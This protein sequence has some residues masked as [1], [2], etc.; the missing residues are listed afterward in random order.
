MEGQSSVHRDVTVRRPK[1][2]HNRRA[3]LMKSV[4]ETTELQANGSIGGNR[5]RSLTKS[6]GADAEFKSKYKLNQQPGAVRSE[7]RTRLH[8]PPGRRRRDRQQSVGAAGRQ[9][10]SI[11]S[12]AAR[13]PS[14]SPER[15]QLSASLRSNH[16]TPRPA[17]LGITAK[18]SSMRIVIGLLGALLWPLVPLAGQDAPSDVQNDRVTLNSYYG[19]IPFY[20]AFHQRMTTRLSILKASRDSELLSEH[21]R[22]SETQRS[23]I[24]STWITDDGLLPEPVRNTLPNANLQVDEFQIDPKFY[25]F[26]EPEQRERLDRLAIEFDGYAGLVLNSV[27]ERVKLSPETVES[28]RTMLSEYHE[29]AW[30]PFFRYEFAGRLP[31]DHKYRRCV[32]VG[33]YAL[34]V[35]KAILSALNDDEQRRLSDWLAKEPPY[36]VSEA[37]R[38]IAPLPEGLFGLARYYK[39]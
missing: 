36:I 26:L 21:L 2:L 18:R 15:C 12:A 9:G 16:P 37:V 3:S 10:E 33:K 5:A 7:T 28:I 14:G 29:S 11:G 23:T 27:A 13:E 20:T 19:G 30:L 34:E 4:S 32:F 38:Q 35:D 8:R 24:E 31:A 17:T 22:L 39:R 6:S 25:Q 1:P